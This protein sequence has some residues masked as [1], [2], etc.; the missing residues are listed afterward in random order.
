MDEEVVEG[1]R[2]GVDVKERDTKEKRR[3]RYRELSCM[4]VRKARAQVAPARLGCTCAFS[5]K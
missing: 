3:C 2:V 5:A 1:E 4:G